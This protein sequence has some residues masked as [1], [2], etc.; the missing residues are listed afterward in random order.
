MVKKFNVKRLRLKIFS[1]LFLVALLTLEIGP[2]AVKAAGNTLQYYSPGLVRVG[3]DSY[4]GK[5]VWFSNATLGGI[6][7]YCVDY[8]FAAP[9]GNM[10]YSRN[11]SDQGLAI[12]VH[13][14]PNSTPSQMGVDT[15]D[16]AYMATQMA[17][18]EILQRT[19]ESQKAGRIFKVSNITP[20]AGKED[21]YNK[22]KAAASRL[23]ALA[24]SDPITDIPTLTVTTSNAVL[25]YIDGDALMG[26]YKVDLSEFRG[27]KLKSLTATL[28]GAPSSARVTDANGN[29]KTS[30][31]SGDSVYVRMSASEESTTFKLNFH[32]DLDRMIGRIYSQ[33]DSTQDYVILDTTPNTIDQSVKIGWTKARDL[34]GIEL[35]KVDQDNNPVV[36]A[37]FELTRSDGTKIGDVTTGV[38]G[39][40]TFTNVPVGDYVLTETEAPS[41]Y[42]IINKTTNVTVKK[43]EVTQVKVENKR[44]KAAVIIAKTYEDKETP[45]Q[46]VKFEISNEKGEVLQTIT[47]NERGLAGVKDLPLGTYYYK[48]IEAPENVKM[49]TEK[50]QFTLSEDD[51]VLIVDVVNEKITGSLKITKVDES[52]NSIA[53]VKFQILDKDKNLVEELVTDSNG[54]A[55]SK[56]LEPGTYYYKEI[57]APAEYVL[58]TREF[59]FKV[60][61]SGS[62]VPVKVVNQHAKGTL[63]ITKYDDKGST[64]EGVTFNILDENK[65]V[66]DTIKT[67]K[68][69]KATSKE[70]PLGTYYYKETSAPE[71]LV[72]DSKEH[73]FI[74]ADN[75]QVIKKT[76]VNTTS[77]GKLKI[78]KVDENSNPLAGVTFEITDKDG[79]KVCDM[80][81]NEEGIAESTELERGTYYYQE[82]KAPDG[83]VIDNTKHE[84]IIEYDGQNVIKNVIN[85]YAKGKLKITKLVD[86]TDEPLSNVKFAVLD[87]DRNVIEEIVTDEN[88]VAQTGDLRVGTYYFKEIEAPQGYIMDKD[89]HEFKIVSNEDVIDAVVY[90]AKETLPKTG[91]V[92]SDNMIIV[93]IVTAIGVAGYGVMKALSTKED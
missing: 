7:A 87:S 30:V 76:V 21:F 32:V 64:I 90:N 6:T 18:W 72:M 8:S 16:E 89:E 10:T 23:V 83:I 78:I 36:G 26:P 71:N 85:N 28:E 14:Y 25:S 88:G 11:L 40:V 44:M 1:V 79:K 86:G 33:G 17:L 91:G 92:L 15:A 56:Q 3:T 57:S 9:S 31:S 82:T 19:G 50:H 29:T 70:L 74:L 67:D 62:L 49:D 73:A 52:N 55:V 22:T 2:F 93:L 69:G 75:G 20:L 77:H 5:S 45:I 38:D 37:K 80:T 84:F 4:N 60:D 59:E 51:Q 35:V 43:G 48:E 53:G 58:D 63:E 81:T 66:V 54:V 24:E 34:G 39:K 46:N 61:N 13:G 65:N 68:N 41:G 12:L 27:S 42:S 47:T